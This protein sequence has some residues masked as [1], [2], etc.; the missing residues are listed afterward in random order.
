MSKAIRWQVPFASI[1]G[2]QYR[3]DIY[4]E[5]DGTWSGVTTLQAGETPFVTSEDDSDD[6]FAPVRTQ[7]GTL[8]ICTLLPDGGRI[9]LDDL[10]PA[11]N[12]ARPV[13]LI[14]L[15][16][17]NAIEWQGFLSSEMYNQPYSSIP[18]NLS[19]PVI[20]VLSA[21]AS[22]QLTTATYTGTM[23]VWD[24]LIDA[25]QEIDNAC[26]MQQFE[27]LHCSQTDIDF[28]N[29]Y[30]D[31]SALFS[32]EEVVNGMSTS[33][34]VE[35][36]T[37]Q[38]F[39]SRICTFM[40]W[41]AREIGNEIYLE[42]VGETIGMERRTIE[43][44]PTMTQESIQEQGIESLGWMGT[45]HQRS[46]YQGVQSAKVVAEI[47]SLT[48]KIQMPKF[49]GVSP[50]ASYTKTAERYN[51][52]SPKYV[53][54]DN[55]VDQSS[56]SAYSNCK[57]T[58][59]HAGKFYLG[60]SGY[61]SEYIG[62][63][64]KTNFINHAFLR[65][66]NPFVIQSDDQNNYI[67]YAGA[68]FI[69]FSEKESSS[70]DI[71]S[72]NSGLYCTLLPMTASTAYAI[73]VTQPI[74]RMNSVQ[75]FSMYG[76][77]IHI[78]S[79]MLFMGICVNRS[80]LSYSAINDN[81]SDGI[82]GD[83]VVMP[84]VLKIGNYYYNGSTW[85]TTA[86]SFSVIIR[87]SGID[88][89]IYIDGLMEGIVELRILPNVITTSSQSSV[90]FETIFKTLSVEYT[91]PTDLLMNDQSSNIYYRSL[92]T[93]FRDEKNISSKFATIRNNKP[94]PSL[95]ISDPTSDTMDRYAS[96]ITYNTDA[97]GTT[98]SRRPEVDLL[99]RLAAYYGAA[100]QT[101]S[102]E[103][104]HIDTPLPLLRLKDI[105]YATGFGGSLC[106]GII[107]DR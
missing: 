84:L 95:I 50:T 2:T 74:F 56:T 66:N 48:M 28:L 47:D 19:I 22:V 42:R 90:L 36:I 83:S 78:S 63:T 68:A 49:A 1:S 24:V 11:N 35:G 3:V 69:R 18:N 60:Q 12:I 33:Y 37:A 80:W 45:N 10:L 99:N 72:I 55:I 89:T 71:K 94:S 23:K 87:D 39:I 86:S 97:Q 30:I 58:N 16:N 79:T 73:P 4:D 26:G 21:M 31:T 96:S 107:C 51:G 25:I 85:T 5:D 61:T 13:R 43:T 88:T 52:G 76:G 67:R 104:A 75:K 46:I 38:E 7:T 64:T 59:C 62:V 93:L 103:V 82:L 17:S 70:A 44:T 53:Y 105:D 29:K 27:Y 98:E 15:S 40:G 77:S 91:A 20:S 102:L 9:S 14:N 65:T 32:I 106:I 81:I 57:F 101:L 41:V 34:N 8:Q 92:L 54:I 100:R 6:Y